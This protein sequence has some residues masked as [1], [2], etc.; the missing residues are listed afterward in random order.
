MQEN[1]KSK[2]KRRPKIFIVLQLPLELLSAPKIE[3]GEVVQG[4]YTKASITKSTKRF[5]IKIP[6]LVHPF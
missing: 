6:T 2:D 5:L 3:I 1:T 4:M